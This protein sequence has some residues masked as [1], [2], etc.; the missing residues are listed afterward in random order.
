MLHTVGAHASDFRNSAWLVFVNDFAN[1][2]RFSVCDLRRDYQNA[3]KSQSVFPNFELRELRKGL[4]FRHGIITA[5]C[6]EL[7]HSFAMPFSE[8]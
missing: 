4:F 3:H 8:V 1:V 7:F 2:P 5:G 6:F